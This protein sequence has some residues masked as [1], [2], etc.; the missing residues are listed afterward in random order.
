MSEDRNVTNISAVTVNATVLSELLGV[1]DRRV[2][3]LA[4]EGILIR[5]AKGRYKLAESMKNYILTLR[6][7][8]QDSEEKIYGETLDLDAE[9]AKH[10]VVK[11]QMS[12][13]KLQLMK[14]QLHKSED[15][16]AV[17]CDM[18]TA[19]RSRLMNQPAKSAP[20]LANMYDAGQIQSYLEKEM[21]DALLELRQYEPKE[22]YN[23]DYI[24]LGDDKIAGPQ[25]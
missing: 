2:R 15:V 12:E 11:I 4:E 17:M 20:V 3:Q 23:E 16:R 9:K 21:T 24:E 10:E 6:I 5:A 1:S 19:F 18:L 25:N 13:L 8:N 7:A 14:G 22:F